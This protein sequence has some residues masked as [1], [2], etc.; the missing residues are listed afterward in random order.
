M[1]QP[2][3][4]IGRKAYGHIP[5]LPDSRVTKG[6]HHIHEGGAVI[7]TRKARD[8][9]DTI[10]VQEKLDGCLTWRTPILTDHGPLGIGVVVNQKLPVKVLSY[11]CEMG[12]A[13]YKP[14]T[15]YHSAQRHIPWV[16]VTVKT[17]ARGTPTKA[18]ICTLNHRFYNQGQWVEAG[19][20]CA[21]DIVA[22]VADRISSEAEQV[23][24]GGLLGDS[25]IVQPRA[26][27]LPG[28]TFCH[29]K[30]QSDYFAFKLRLLGAIVHEIKGSRGGFPGSTNNRRALSRF[31]PVLSYLIRDLC[32]REGKKWI[33]IEW[34]RHLS[35]LALAIWY[36]DDGSCRFNSEQRPRAHLSTNG[37]P[38]EQVRIL[39]KMLSDRFRVDNGVFDY[40]GPTIV[41]TA[42]GTERFFDLIYPYVPSCMKYKLSAS[43]HGRP[44]VFD[45]DWSFPSY[46]GIVETEVLRIE[47]E[48]FSVWEVP[49]TQYDL[50][51]ADNHN[52]FA[53]GVLVHNSCVAVALQGGRLYPLT[54]GG[55]PAESSPFENHRLFAQWVWDHEDRFRR[56][57]RDGE[58]I[59][60][61][62]LAQAHGT[63][64]DLTEREPFGV[65]DIMQGDV[66]LAYDEFYERV[67]GYF[68][69]PSLLHIGPPL[70]VEDAMALHHEVHWPC[71]EIEGVVYRVERGGKVDFLAKYVRPDK[72]DGKYLP[73]VSGGKDPVWNWRPIL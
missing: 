6:D 12:I 65:F 14:I 23:V 44:C 70:S 7:C 34:A 52:Y 11:N 36:M 40:K 13:E 41:L 28:F 68:E 10:I 37:F 15:R 38:V 32:Q 27:N 63:I 50:T 72:V 55:R 21:G 18:I 54:R 42:D 66:R 64:Y 39:S 8:H 19:R 71:D 20:L 17:K 61:E 48:G 51:V 56:V 43:Y 60:G 58:R 49:N 1:N 62:W 24:L 67:S 25:S 3:K 2:A 69:R 57:L 73:Q 35:P 22:H 47:K 29:A 4:P 31:T 53:S 26:S 30:H 16:R 5:H 59:I 9:R 33:T 46:T 45:G